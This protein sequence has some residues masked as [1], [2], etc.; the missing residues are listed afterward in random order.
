[1]TTIKGSVKITETEADGI[2]REVAGLLSAL[3]AKNRLNPDSLRSVLISGTDDLPGGFAEEA[4][5]LAGL[6]T[7][8]VYTVQQF[9]YQADMDCCIQVVLYPKAL[10]TEPVNLLLGCESWGEQV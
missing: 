1:M 2:A 10:P 7:V 3:L 5:A 4:I 8:P 6:Q 9:R